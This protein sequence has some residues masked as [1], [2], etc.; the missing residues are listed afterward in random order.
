MEG[1]IFFTF[2]LQKAS[3]SWARISLVMRNHLLP[4]LTA[5]ALSPSLLT[6][7]EVPITK[8]K[9]APETPAVEI[10]FVLD[11]TGS[12]GGLI[13]AAK[14]KIWSIANET[15]TYK[16]KEIRFGLIG[17]RD[18]KDEYITK[19]TDLTTDLDAVHTDLTSYVAR[20]GGD[21]PESVNQ[22][23]TEA[24]TD[25]KW[26]TDPKV[27]KLIFLVGDAPPHMDYPQ[28]MQYPE[29]CKLAQKKGILINT[30]LCGNN[31]STA[32][33]WKE[34]AG[35]G[36]G[37]Y[38]AIPQTGGAVAIA[39]PFDAQLQKLSVS[40]NDTVA[41]WGD[42][43]Q[44]R[45]FNSKL[46]AINEASLENQATRAKYAAENYVNTQVVSGRGDLVNDWSEGTVKLEEIK[47]EELEGDLKGLK[48]KT[49][50]AKLKEKKSKRT[51]LQKEVAELTKKRDAFIAEQQK[52]NGKEEKKDSFDLK[53]SEILKSQLAPSNK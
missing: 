13:A 6:A 39:T 27:R 52:K 42:H 14:R 26:S 38:A 30:I 43:A 21:G 8:I 23:L 31:Q 28:E 24:V 34:I 5:F 29:A 41:C 11:T 50:E 9:T 51:K 4:L 33:I 17:Y 45:S 36:A 12:M 40:L 16:P 2:S 46:K 1:A 15:V 53:V 48:G 19:M 35:M 44:R 3:A 10:C 22:A 20:G 47:P 37:Q 25:I 49:L 7:K 18:R 32:S